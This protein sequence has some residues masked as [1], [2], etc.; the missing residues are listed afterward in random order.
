MKGFVCVCVC[1]CLS[2][3]FI[4]LKKLVSTGSIQ[5]PLTFWFFSIFV[6]TWFSLFSWSHCMINSSW[7]IVHFYHFYTFIEGIP[8][9]VMV[10]AMDIVSEFELQ[11]RYYIHFRTNILEKR[12]NPHYYPNNE[13]NS[14]TAILLEDV[15]ISNMHQLT[16]P[17]NALLNK[18]SKWMWTECIW[19]DQKSPNIWFT[20]KT[21]WSHIKNFRRIRCKWFGNWS[22]YMT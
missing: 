21:F 1:V 20:T 19:K 15:Y 17:L 3:A 22:S 16:A 9:G 13:L 11:S 6:T 10:K 12:M 2:G 4:T 18:D 5:I 14:I 7:N 8:R